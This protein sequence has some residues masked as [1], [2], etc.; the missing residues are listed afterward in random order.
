MLKWA[1]AGFLFFVGIIF[2]IVIY[3]TGYFKEVHI[4]AA[5]KGPYTLIYQDHFGPYHKIPPVIAAVED[6]MIT[7]GHTCSLA[8]GRYLDAVSYTHLTLPTIYSV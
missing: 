2:S 1:F 4:A 8:F 6:K 5:T 7:L 3:R